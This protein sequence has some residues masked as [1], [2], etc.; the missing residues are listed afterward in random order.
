MTTGALTKREERGV[1]PWFRFAPI[2]EEMRDLVSR[3]L[4]SGHE[5]IWPAGAIGSLDVSETDAQVEVRLDLPGVDA[6]DLD[7]Q[8]N[9]N[10]LTVSGERKEEKEEKDKMYHRVERRCG[11]FSRSITLPCPVKQEAVDAQYRDG[12]LAIKLP[13][14]E[15]AKARKIKV[16]T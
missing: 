3:M 9:E 11:S 4:G 1:R 10:V 7:I 8:I 5:V 16:K 6:K 14:S 13:K 15:E 12:V 2:E